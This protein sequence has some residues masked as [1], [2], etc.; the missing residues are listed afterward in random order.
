MSLSASLPLDFLVYAAAVGEILWASV[1]ANSNAKRADR[2][3]QLTG[4]EDLE[5]T[6][7]IMLICLSGV[8][9]FS[10]AL[11]KPL[12]IVS[13]RLIRRDGLWSRAESCCAMG[14]A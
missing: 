12:P 1:L 14:G 2:I 13:A 5:P 11:F 7:V 8:H 10:N 3:G 6:A 9:V 4:Y